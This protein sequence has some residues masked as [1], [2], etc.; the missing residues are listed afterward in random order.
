MHRLLKKLGYT[1]F[2][3]VL[4]PSSAVAKDSFIV[5]DIRVEGL[6]RISPGTVFNYLP[7]RVGDEFD[8]S[9]SAEAVRA[10][11]KT[12][13][14]RDVRLEREGDVLVVI[15][16]ER[17]TIAEITVTGNKDIGTE[18]LL[19]GLKKIGF[20]EGG[21]F[22]R[23]LLDKVEQELRRQYF[24]QGKYGVKLDSQVKK[25]GANRVA[26]TI[27][28]TEGRA[29]RIKQINI[30]GNRAY[31]DKALIKKFKLTTPTLFSFFTKS[32][33]YSKQK[34]SADLEALRSHYLDHG[35][36]N[37]NI[38]STQVS[39]TPDKSDIYITINVSEGNR[40]TL[41]E[42]KLAGDLIVP[43]DDL[44]PLVTTKR[45]MVFSRKAVTQTS[46]NLTERLGDEG[47]A[48]ANVN[49]VPEID[50]AKK[51]VALSYFIDPGKRVYVRRINFSG[52]TK[53]RDE[54]LRREMRQLEGAWF[55][56]SKVNRSKVRLQRLG[57]FE[58]INAETPPVPGTTDQVDVNFAVTERASGNLLL[59]LGFSQTQGLIFNTQITQDNF[60]GTGNRVKFAFNNSDVN[61]IFALGYT[62][63]YYTPQGISRGFDVSYRETD[64]ARANV[65]RFDSKVLSGGINFGIPVTEYQFVNIGLAYEDTE[66]DVDPRFVSQQVND[67]IERE[68]NQFNVLRF[69]T[70]FAYD[71]RNKALLPDSGVLHRV[72]AEAAIPGG[73]LRYYKLEYDTHWYYPL[74]EDYIL[75][76]R[77]LVGYG[78]GYEGT[79]E[80]PFFENFYAGGPRSVRGYEENTLGPE[81]GDG[82]ALGGNF[83]VVGNAEII[84]PVPFLQDVK[85]V[86]V[87]AFV[88][89]GNVFG[90]GDVFGR[91]D[92]IDPGELRL[93]AGL[94]GIWL[95]PFGV[96][97]VS[98]AQP[99]N[100]QPGD[101]TQP[102]Q[103]TFGA[104]F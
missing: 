85:S 90:R 23:S 87:A 32:D 83:K 68:G 24:S 49:A 71:T 11:F 76:L 18:D 77:G 10:L 94:S 53:T 96:L 75:A 34:L 101:E 70:S 28:I 65:T 17:E 44:F 100:K 79:E 36:I 98:I 30:V 26:V 88:D 22:D 97:S 93:S 104:S 2:L 62:N 57:F 102:F 48:F 3:F 92:D 38:D 61:R 72:R 45:G 58:E 42:V 86:R 13:F 78:D 27:A 8:A 82:R 9:R 4:W 80:L 54:V 29:A 67:F 89:M 7:I 73:D 20:A 103:F 21:V 99:F 43:Q 81:G 52:N 66:I 56:T 12:G 64:A 63:P 60:L 50:N 84:L 46:T 33:Q 5:K 91:S 59:G 16:S 1:V 51:T 35:Y 95:S 6:E 15:V 31:S 14:F 41:S 69:N 19:E 39:I 55:S 74:V 47:Y 37:F 25:L 40:Y